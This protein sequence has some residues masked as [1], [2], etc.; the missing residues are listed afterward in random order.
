MWAPGRYS[1]RLSSRY[2]PSWPQSLSWPCLVPGTGESRRDLTAGLKHPARPRTGRQ[3]ADSHLTSEPVFRAVSSALSGEFLGELL[4]IAFGQRGLEDGAAEG[5]H[6]ACELVLGDLR[7]H[8][9]H[10]G[11]TGFEQVLH[12]PAELGVD[13]RPVERAHERADRAAQ[14]RHARDEEQE[15]EQEPEER[16]G[17]RRRADDPLGCVDVSLAVGVDVDDGKSAQVDDEVLLQALHL[18]IRLPRGLRVLVADY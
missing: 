3:P 8:D 1:V 15:A 17:H 10:G 9:H 7:G 13:A 12:A 14:Q 18:L 2:S 11:V 6:G 5:L 16:T 4:F